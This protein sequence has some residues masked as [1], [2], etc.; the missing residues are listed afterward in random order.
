M[1]EDQVVTSKGGRRLTAVHRIGCCVGALVLCEGKR[2]GVSVE[3]VGDVDAICGENNVE[4]D[5]EK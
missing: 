2:K 3:I 4:V 1:R 5:G